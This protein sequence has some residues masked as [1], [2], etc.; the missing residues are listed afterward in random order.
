[1]AVL[2][3]DFTLDVPEVQALWPRICARHEAVEAAAAK[4]AAQAQT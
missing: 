3:D 4:A 2:R 1:M